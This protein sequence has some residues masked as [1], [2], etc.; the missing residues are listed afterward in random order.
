MP[1][2]AP[3]VEMMLDSALVKAPTEADRQNILAQRQ[4][5]L[6]PVLQQYIQTKTMYLA[7][8]REMRKNT[9]DKYAESRGKLEKNIRQK[10]DEQLKKF[11]GEA[12]ARVAQAFGATKA[13]V[14][15]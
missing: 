9:K 10:F 11:R 8:D 3:T 1:D 7:F 13:E 15:K 14:S 5:V 6:Q 12:E 4:A 2:V